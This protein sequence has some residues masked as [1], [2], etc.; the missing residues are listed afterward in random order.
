MLQHDAD[1]NLYAGVRAVHGAAVWRAGPLPVKRHKAPTCCSE[2]GR[3]RSVCLH[4]VRVLIVLMMGDL[5]R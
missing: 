3:H 2:Q 4:R 1:A 5:W